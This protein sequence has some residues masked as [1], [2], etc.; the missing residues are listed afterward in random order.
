MMFCYL[1]FHYLFLWIMQIKSVQSVFQL[2]FVYYNALLQMLYITVMI[3]NITSNVWFFVRCETLISSWTWDTKAW[4]VRNFSPFNLG[5]GDF[6][7]ILKE[8][9][10]DMRW[11]KEWLQDLIINGRFFF[12]LFTCKNIVRYDWKNVFELCVC[13]HNDN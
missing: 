2:S 10:F 12:H 4:P 3:P 11:M 7:I 5:H 8:K 1:C 6:T 9:F 13:T